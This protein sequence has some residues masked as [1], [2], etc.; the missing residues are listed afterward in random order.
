MADILVT[1]GAGL[2]GS[3]LIR[4]LLQQ[5]N[6]VRALYNSTPLTINNPNL[7]V[8]KCDILDPIELAKTMEG[9]KQ[10]YHCAAIISFHPNEKRK[11]FQVNI[12]GTANVVNA[13]LEE[14]VNK[15]V[16]VSSVAAL[17]RSNN[18]EPRT[19]EMNWDGLATYS[20][21]GKSK[22]LAE[23]EV[24]RGTGE[25][26]NAVVV[27]P[28]IVLGGDNWENG[29]TALFKKAYEEFPW[30]TNG[31][32]GF[33]NV[34][35]VARAMILLMNSEITNERFILNG[36]NIGYK[37]LFSTIANNFGK[38]PPSK[39]ATP[40]LAGVVWR[41]EAIKAGFTGKSPLLTRETAAT[42]QANIS[43]NN[44]KI[45]KVLPSFEF[46]PIDDTIKET[47]ATLKEKYHL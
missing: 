19:E 15:L 2:V 23:M 21:Y 35:D 46:T 30:Y 38:K 45:K 18:N 25:G 11:L 5:G 22:H 1:G 44:E 27:N 12:E 7:E 32:T 29:S 47:C 10:V 6:K 16:H 24:W 41:A 8:F 20:A 26:L 37:H 39:E 33:V 31:S 36:G 28:S 3:E 4:Q 42:A 14:G 34:K 43:Y 17:G 13:C 9:I 40:F